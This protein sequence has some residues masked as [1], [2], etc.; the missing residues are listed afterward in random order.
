MTRSPGRG[1]YDWPQSP[2]AVVRVGPHRRDKR[3]PKDTPIRTIRA[4]QDETRTTLRTL[5]ADRS[6]GTL[7]DDAP[8]YLA[9]VSSQIESHVDRARDVG[10]WVAAHGTIRTAELYR[11]VGKLNET[12][13]GWR[14]ERSASTCNHRRDALTN[15]VR[16]IVGRKAARDLADDLIRFK[17]PPPVPRAR[18]R[19]EIASVLSWLREGSKTRAR[20]ELLHWTGMR[21][22]QMARLEPTAFHL[23]ARIPYVEVPRGKFGRLARVPL[24]PPGVAAAR[25]FV[26]AGA[27]GPWS[28]SAANTRLVTAAKKAGVAPF[29]TYV[30]RHSFATELRHH[31]DVADI[32]SLYGHT[33]PRT[34]EIY[35]VPDLAKQHAAIGKLT[36]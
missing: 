27:W 29:T 26:D 13:A 36:A 4:W 5:P 14:K 15:L 20:L 28:V 23:D 12:L 21:P 22:S 18:P 2:R 1:V 32:Q 6:S 24:V 25:A 34:T 33:D 19:D 9:I 17:A 8:R 7:A 10:Y 11:H 35:A 3:F 31:A 30:I 16:V